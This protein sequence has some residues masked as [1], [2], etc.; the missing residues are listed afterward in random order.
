MNQKV[1]FSDSTHSKKTCIIIVTLKT[2][3]IRSYFLY[4][5]F[6][7]QLKAKGPLQHITV[8]STI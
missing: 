1:T 4:F 5:F 6:P 3:Q 8:I 7:L 2:M